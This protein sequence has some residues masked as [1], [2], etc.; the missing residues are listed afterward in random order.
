MAA[1]SQNRDLLVRQLAWQHEMGIDEILLD[2]PAP[3]EAVTMAALAAP[4]RRWEPVA[5]QQPGRP[6]AVPAVSPASD[7]DAVPIKRPV[8]VAKLC[9]TEILTEGRGFA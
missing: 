5:A 8:V 2:E 4:S 7:A 6:L 1:N 9:I 3:D